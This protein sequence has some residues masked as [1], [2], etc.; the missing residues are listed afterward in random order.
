MK[1][2]NVSVFVQPWKLF[3]EENNV[4]G[5]WLHKTYSSLC[6]EFLKKM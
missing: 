6:V 2:V 5:W 3:M 4:N 1:Y